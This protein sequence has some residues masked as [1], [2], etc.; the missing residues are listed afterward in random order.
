MSQLV[1]VPPGPVYYYI[2]T[3][4]KLTRDILKWGG[5]FCTRSSKKYK[6][7]NTVKIE[8]IYAVPDYFC[9]VK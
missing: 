5:G 1:N 6:H 9:A 3:G 4:I 8:I 7:V 2:G